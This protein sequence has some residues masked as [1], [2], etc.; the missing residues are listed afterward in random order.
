[1]VSMRELL[2]NAF[3][4]SRDHERLEAAIEEE[5][6]RFVGASLRGCNACDGW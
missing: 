5:V 4:L 6:V 2:A 3:N 1:M